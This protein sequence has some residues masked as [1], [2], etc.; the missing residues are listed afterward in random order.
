M[1]PHALRHS[2]AMRLRKGGVSTSDLARFMRDEVET[3]ESFYGAN[4]GIEQRLARAV[5]RAAEA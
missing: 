4:D 2:A 3:V 5:E 1:T